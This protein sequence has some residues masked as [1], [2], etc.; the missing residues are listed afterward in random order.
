MAE[1]GAELAR[2]VVAC[3]GADTC[4]LAVTQSPRPRR[5]H[6][7]GARR[8][9]A[10]RGRRRPHQH[11]RLHQLVRPAPHLRHRV[12][13]PRAPGAR[14]G[15]ARLP[16]A[17]R[18]PRRPTCE[19]EFGEKAVEAAGQG[20]VRRPSCGSSGGSPASASAGETFA[21]W[22][23]RAGGAAAVGTTLKELDDFPTARR[24][25]R[26]LRRLRRDRS[27]RGRGR[28]QRV[29]HVT[30]SSRPSTTTADTAIPDLARAR[31]RV[32]GA[33]AR[34][35]RR[36]RSAWAWERFGDRHGAGG[37]VPGLRA[38]RPRGAGGLDIEVVFLDTQY[39]FAETLW[40]VEQV[41]ERY[42]LNLTVMQP[43][44]AARRPLA[45]RPRRAA[46]RVRKVEPLDA[47]AR[48]QGRRG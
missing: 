26:L 18:R 5:R 45:G 4:N 33:R 20:R 21:D 22:L 27:V 11:L 10:G 34:R 8:G 36:P 48:R 47:G 7:P 30:D 40:Y 17:A 39:H 23:D 14:P 24:S 31:R 16:D 12:L 42:D 37:V 46:A 44:V 41:R 3:P 1:P 2:D 43:E 15:R 6:R 32:G 13:R 25:A 29:R 35:P 28:R 38:H 19:I 9:R